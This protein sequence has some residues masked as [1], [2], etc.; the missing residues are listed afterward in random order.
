VSL[1]LAASALADDGQIIP[2]ILTLEW[3]PEEVEQPDYYQAFEVALCGPLEDTAATDDTLFTPTVFDDTDVVLADYELQPDFW[4]IP[5]PSQDDEWVKP[6][7]I[8]AEEDGAEDATITVLVG[9]DQDDEISRPVA[10]EADDA[11][12][13]DAE[14]LFGQPI[15]DAPAPVDDTLF[16]PVTD[17]TEAEQPETDDSFS[18]G[19]FDDAPV[20]DDTAFAPVMDET[21]PDEAEFDDSFSLAPLEDTPPTDDEIVQAVVLD[22][23]IDATID[24]ATDYDFQY[25]PPQ[26]DTVSVPQAYGWTTH[27]YKK[28]NKRKRKP[29]DIEEF[30]NMF[31]TRL[32]DEAPAPIAA[33]AYE[34][35]AASKAYLKANEDAAEAKALLAKALAEINEFY[36]LLRAADKRRRDEQ[37]EDDIE[38]FLLLGF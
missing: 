13:D 32:I 22:D 14:A 8:E 30:F 15:D 21:L 20:T 31:E 1:L 7:L 12:Q 17:D 25:I 18:L 6:L 26:D 19:P 4:A 38:E 9:I 36:A 10:I 23:G 11:E 37:D 3:Q 29:S 24:E 35:Q 34:A 16:A 27:F 5:P 28:R 2:P 33:Q